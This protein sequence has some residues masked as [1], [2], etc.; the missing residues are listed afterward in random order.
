MSLSINTNIASLS[1][2]RALSNSQSDAATAM[3]RLSTGLRINSA[4]DDAA[5]LAIANSFTSQVKGLQQ[6]SR[7][8]SDAV[9]LLQTAEG[10]LQS[11]TDNLQRIRELAVQ[12]SNGTL[13]AADRSALNEEVLQLRDE[14]DRVA[15]STTFSSVAILSGS[16]GTP[17]AAQTFNFQVG[18]G[19]DTAVDRMAVEIADFNTAHL[20]GG[21]TG[22]STNAGTEITG[23]LTALNITVGA[24]S[25]TTVALPTDNTTLFDNTTNYASDVAA[26]IVTASGNKVTATASD[27]S[28]SL[29]VINA[30]GTKD[31][32]DTAKV[33]VNGVDVDVSSALSG[34]SITASEIKTIFNASTA[35]N[36]STGTASTTIAASVDAN[37]NLIFTDTSG[38]NLSASYSITDTTNE[39]TTSDFTL[40]TGFSS[41]AASG[42]AVTQNVA[43]SLGTFGGPTNVAGTTPAAADKLQFQFF[44]DTTLVDIELSGADILKTGTDLAT[45]LNTALQASTYSQ[46]ADMTIAYDAVNQDFELTNSNANPK[47]FAI[48]TQGTGGITL[49]EGASVTTGSSFTGTGSSNIAAVTGFGKLTVASTSE[50][51]A[52]SGASATA[53]GLG[54]SAS[55]GH[56]TAGGTVSAVSVDTQSNAQSAI[57]TIDSALGMVN[58]G[59]AKM[60]AY[61]ARFD[62]VVSSVGIAVENAQ[63]SRARVLDADFA[64]ESAALAKTQVL[65]QAGISVLAQANA[66]PQQ[67]LALLQ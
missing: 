21:I 31:T 62:S 29:G 49:V 64:Q 28:V 30:T 57:Q 25:A 45:A 67:V 11:I 20:G 41:T 22:T 19:N 36:S 2:Q 63:A 59:R 40:G 7:N 13:G 3:Q 65:Q 61:Q 54:T 39:T 18:D 24:G 55:T 60:G 48:K 10:G 52:F 56:T 32:T 9:S 6:A 8:A 66:M 33:T 37:G 46:K 47:S 23:A 53:S 16:A 51:F 12:A 14:I 26:A 58:E 4:K 1:A 34:G 5:G 43:V 42:A 27:S 50:T 35:F 15:T 38:K 44:D 17:G